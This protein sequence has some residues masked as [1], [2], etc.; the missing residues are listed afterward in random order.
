MV[1]L[2]ENERSSSLLG[3]SRPHF[4]ANSL[5]RHDKRGPWSYH[6]SG[7]PTSKEKVMLPMTKSRSGGSSN[8]ASNWFWLTDWQIDYSDPRVDPTSG[9]QYSRSFDDPDDLW[10]PVAPTSGYG[11]V[12][13]RRWVRV[14]KRRM[15]L[16]KGYVR[17]NEDG[18][19]M[20]GSAVDV[21]R[22]YLDQ[23]EDLVQNAKDTAAAA[24]AA[25]PEPSAA[26]YDATMLR[27]V[28]S[29]LR[30]YEEAVQM[31]LAGIKTDMNQ[32]RK[33]QATILVKSHSAHIEKLNA[34]ITALGSK[35]STPVGPVQHNSEL[36]RELGLT[37]SVSMQ[38]GDRREGYGPDSS[39]TTDLDANPWSRDSGGTIEDQPAW[40]IVQHDD[41]SPTL[42]AVVLGQ[43]PAENGA[44]GAEDVDIQDGPR[45]FVWEADVNVKECR[46][47]ERRFGLLVRRHHCRRCGLIVCDRCS[48]SR[49]YLNAS[50]ILQDPNAPNEQAQVLASQHHRVCDKCYADLGMRRA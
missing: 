36:A 30:V 6:P 24:A 10:T 18:E 31:L 16:D 49:T 45:S 17:G 50:E 44:Y 37:N 46:W 23:A 48:T 27:R 28:T 25:A 39:L 42:N 14:M 40:T 9:W 34:Q 3:L 4:S 19:G 41:G 11:W 35:L 1:I 26:S 43:D 32:F 5:T 47:C 20:G 2:H 29:E 12:R 8:G 7:I 38:S 13:R 33:H 21:Q 22:D 15:D